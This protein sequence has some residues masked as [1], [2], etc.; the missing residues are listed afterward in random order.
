MRARARGENQINKQTKKKYKKNMKTFFS[1]Y[2]KMKNVRHASRH[3]GENQRQRKRKE[4][5]K[6]A[7][8][9]FAP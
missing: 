5:L 8:T 6:R 7:H 4:K 2:V 3:I 9:K 1:G